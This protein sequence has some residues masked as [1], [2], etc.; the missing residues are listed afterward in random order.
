MADELRG[1]TAS[2]RTARSGALSA[3]V[4]YFDAALTVEQHEAEQLRKHDASF[5]T[6]HYT[7]PIRRG[8]TRQR[9]LV[10]AALLAGLGSIGLWLALAS[11]TK[12]M[13]V[14]PQ[15]SDGAQ[16]VAM[17]PAAAPA[18]AVRNR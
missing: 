13:V 10:A 18:A 16:P 15:A 1:N 6:V 11:P 2:T 17:P 5:K 4:P 8:R 9:L 14:R 7:E 12:P 3:G